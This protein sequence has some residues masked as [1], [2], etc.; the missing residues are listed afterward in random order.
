MVEHTNEVNTV[1][2]VLGIALMMIGAWLAKKQLDWRPLERRNRRGL[3]IRPP[4]AWWRQIANTLR[5][6]RSR[7]G[8]TP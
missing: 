4:G 6:R 3:P 7:V 2:V 8:R 5:V 1:A